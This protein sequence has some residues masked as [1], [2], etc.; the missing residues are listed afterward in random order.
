MSESNGQQMLPCPVCT[1]PGEVR[2]TKKDKPVSHLR[3]MRR[4]GVRAWT[5][6]NRRILPP[7][8]T[9]QQ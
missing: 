3:S 6:R 2:V 5:V 9:D 1:Q 7:I 8:G 4:P